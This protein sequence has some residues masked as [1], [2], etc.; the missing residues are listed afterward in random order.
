MKKS[1]V[2]GVFSNIGSGGGGYAV[3]LPAGTFAAAQALTEVVGCRAYAADSAGGLT[4]TI[5][6]APS[7]LYPTASLSGSGL[8]GDAGGAGSGGSESSLFLLLRI[9]LPSLPLFYF[10]STLCIHHRTGREH[11]L[12]SH[13]L[14]R[15]HG[16]YRG[17][18]NDCYRRGICK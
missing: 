8:C 16:N 18:D 7:V 4:F 2:V 15:L 11:L 10:L 13:Y 1:S 17:L 6:Q 5:G 9:L 14:P 3:A 12:T